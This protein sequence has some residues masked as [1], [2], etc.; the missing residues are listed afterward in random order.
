MGADAQ[1]ILAIDQ[2]TTN[3]KAVLVDERGRVA[4]VGTAPVGVTSPRPGWVEQDPQRI[5]SSVVTAVRNCYAALAA[6]PR[7][8][9][10]ALSTQRESILAW[11]ASTGEPIGPLIGWQDR[12]TVGWCAEMVDD[13]GRR[14]VRERTGLQVDPMFSAP[15]LRWLLDHLPD[16]VSVDDVRAGTV[17]A[18]LIWRL[19]GGEAHVCEAGNASRTLLYDITTL[20]WS[21]ELLDVFGIPASVLPAPLPSA[22]S[23]GRCAGAAP[24][25]D[26]TPIVAVLADSHAALFGHGCTAVG[27]TKATYGT[28]SS[29]MTPVAT[30]PAAGSPVPTTLAWLIDGIPTY[31][32]EGNVLSSGATLAWTADILT[33]GDVAALIELAGTV[34][35]SGGVTLIPAFTGLGAPHWDRTAVALFS[36][37][38]TATGRGHLARAAVDSVAHQICDIID[39][40]EN[41]TGRLHTLRADG[42]ATVADLVMQTQ[43]DLLDRTVEVPDVV[44]VSAIGAGKLAWQ[45]L[46]S[47]HRWDGSMA[48]RYTGNL[49]DKD[50]ATRRARW[51]DELA[52]ARLTPRRS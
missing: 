30:V 44:E 50:R 36:G 42:G 47:G 45:R 43:A 23:F 11:R 9:G 49:G 51:A 28:G 33:S 22:A 8:A 12:R 20:N 7:L 29:V 48:R 35:D 17:D 5:W 18:W 52:R 6:P 13:P 24:I 1:L 19:T 31:A 3:S 39:V 14:M 38:T 40:I 32:L 4:A 15:K 34:A 27:M 37:M 25:P 21:P 10:V 26:G 46:G 2:G 16:D 41:T